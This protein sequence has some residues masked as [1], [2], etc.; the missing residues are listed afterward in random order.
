MSD[1]L[2]YDPR[3]KMQVK[4]LLYQTL[5]APVDKHFKKRIDALI[6]KNSSLVNSPHR[7]FVY[8]GELYTLENSKPPVKFNRLVPELKPLME[9]YLKDIKVLNEHELP[10]VMN[11]F[12]Q[13]LNSSDSLKDYLHTLPTYLHPALNK[14]I[15]TCPCRA[16]T[17]SEDSIEAL[18]TKNSESISL[19]GQRMAK[20]LIL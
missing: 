8:R 9:A 7:S 2:Q 17:L 1:P 5:Y 18:N 15:T 3:T 6:T 10:Y 20:N 14:L 16:C 19:M 12:N 4:E 11:Y 13:V